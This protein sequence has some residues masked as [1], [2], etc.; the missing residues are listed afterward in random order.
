MR[1]PSEGRGGEERR[2]TGAADVMLSFAPT[3]F[4]SSSVRAFGVVFSIT[5]S[6]MTLMFHGQKR[7]QMTGWGGHGRPVEPCAKFSASKRTVRFYQLHPSGSRWI[8]ADGVFGPPFDHE[9]G[10]HHPWHGHSVRGHQKQDRQGLRQSAR[11][12]CGGGSGLR[13]RQRDDRRHGSRHITRFDASTGRE[14][15][16]RYFA[17]YRRHRRCHLGV[18]TR[19]TMWSCSSTP[20]IKWTVRKKP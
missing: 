4:T 6:A 20:T 16:A 13:R 14:F 3:R 12:R 17:V 11:H 15:S 10:S 19:F 18:P 1:K 8:G 5:Q 9:G 7:T 2:A